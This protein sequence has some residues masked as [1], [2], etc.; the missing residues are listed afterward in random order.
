MQRSANTPTT[1]TLSLHRPSA[2][3]ARSSQMS[4]T[5]A[6]GNPEPWVQQRKKR[7]RPRSMTS[8]PPVF[9]IST[10]KRFA[11][12]CET[13]CDAVIIRDYI[14]WH[15]DATLADGKVHTHWHI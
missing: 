15:V 13:E 12:L 10:R 1:S 14:V 7:S 4:F 6:P 11:P 3:G 9:E 5:L 8:P 2:P